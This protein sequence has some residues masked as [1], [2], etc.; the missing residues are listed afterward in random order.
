MFTQ[1]RDFALHK[2]LSHTEFSASSISQD[3]G[4][5]NKMRYESVSGYCVSCDSVLNG[6]YGEIAEVAQ[7]YNGIDDRARWPWVDEEV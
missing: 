4:W 1:E 6:W 2:S 3:D 5:Y 7:E